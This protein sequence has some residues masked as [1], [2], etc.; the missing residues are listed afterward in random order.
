MAR[1]GSVSQAL[2]AKTVSSAMKNMLLLL[3]ITQGTV[4]CTDSARFL[5]RKKL[6]SLTYYYGFPTLFVTLNPADVLHPFT[7]RC[8]LLAEHQTLPLENLDSHLAAVLKSTNLWHVVAQDPTAAVEAFHLH[9]NTFLR[10]LLDISPD[11]HDLPSD[12]TASLHG[13][14]LFGPIQAAFG[15]IEPQQRGSLHIHWVIFLAGFQSPQAL[16]H[17]FC[18]NLPLLESCLWKWVNSIL[19]TSFEHVPSML[20]LP[21][22]LL[23]GLRPLPYSDENLRLMHP[24]YLQHIS[25]S[26]DFWFAAD[27][28]RLLP[29]EGPFLDP[30]TNAPV[31][32]LVFVPWSAEYMRHLADP[33]ESST[34][35]LLLLFDLRNSVVQSGLLHTCKPKS[36]AKGKMGKLGYCRLGFHH[37]LDISTPGHPYTWERCHGR[38]LVPLPHLG[39]QPPNIGAFL[40]QRHH[41][42]FG[43]I[44]PGILAHCKCNHDIS[45]LLRFPHRDHLH[46]DCGAVIAAEMA[47]SMSALLFYVTSYTTKVQP[48]MTSLWALLQS[49][50]S[51]LLADLEKSDR[52]L[53]IPQ[54][55]RAHKTLSRLLLACQKK[56]HK[57][58]QEMVSY[59]LGYE[60]FYCTHPF[61]KLA[62]GTLAAQLLTLHPVP[63]MATAD[64]HRQ[65]QPQSLIVPHQNPNQEDGPT[66]TWSFHSDVDID[67]PQR[68]PIL[69][70]WPWY[71]YCAGVAPINIHR[72]TGPETATIPFAET[73]PKRNQCRQQV[74]TVNAWRIPELLGPRIPSVTEDA[75][76]RAVTLLLLFKPWVKLEDLLPA[77]SGCACW[78]DTWSRYEANLRAQLP[79]SNHRPAVLTSAY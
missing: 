4:P 46:S 50:T 65:A 25:D 48:Q 53:P 47:A 21:L 23:K 24:T 37:W 38:E 29:A 73:H 68:G 5:M 31:T 3:K 14:G 66:L 11:S 27:P 16:L 72:S 40:T 19:A 78:H 64:V 58:M 75:E 51:R 30:N 15:A 18:E 20:G 39:T 12:G 8:S 60:D 7:W 2:Q 44:H 55:Q 62:W 10:Q 61:Q 74:R 52:A 35:P 57:S 41:Q 59:L 69:A 70:E 6:Q 71:F 63:A 43:R 32:E 49:A 36:C 17:R 9:I 22:N 45:L 79:A 34:W 67:Y 56:Q 54:S 33:P 26:R 77:A 42:Y 13:Q 76:K 28:T 1:H